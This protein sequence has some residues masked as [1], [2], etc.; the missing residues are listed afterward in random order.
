MDILLFF[1]CV[2]LVLSVKPRA[3]GIIGEGFYTEL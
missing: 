2:V 3:L 1:Y